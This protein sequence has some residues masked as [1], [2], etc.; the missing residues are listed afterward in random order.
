[1]VN[2]FA[3]KLAP[4]ELDEL[5]S[6]PEVL[7][8]VPDRIIRMPVR[9]QRAPGAASAKAGSVSSLAS[10]GSLCDTLEPE[11]LQLTHTAFLDPSTPQA[12][13]VLDGTGVPV[14]GSGVKVA[15]IADGIDT[16]VPGFTR[17]DG[18]KVFIDYQSF[19]GDPA[20]TPTQGGEAFGDAS[21]IAAQDVPNGRPLT[22]DIST[23]VNPAHPLPSP[24]NIRVRGVA[25]GASLVGLDVYSNLGYSASPRRGCRRSTGPSSTTRWTSSTSRSARTYIP[26]T[27]T[28][29]SRSPM[30]RQSA[31]A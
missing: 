30:L 9:Q 18:S 15:V 8:V 23:F 5:S 24:C 7:A 14:T 21:S 29:P 11:A 17:P 16:T 19:T 3:S 31:R 12:Q 27:P 26:M 4:S 22:Y 13:E 20:G 25:P 28:T 1:M 10:T 2:G 6:R